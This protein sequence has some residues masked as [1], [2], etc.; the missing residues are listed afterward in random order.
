MSEYTDTI[1]LECNRKQSP[2]FLSKIEAGNPAH[3]TNNVG[4]GV[5]LDIGDQISVHSAYMS[6]IG[7]EAATI[8]IKGQDARDNLGRGQIFNMSDTIKIKKTNASF[9]G[10]ISYEY[11]P[12]DVPVQINDNEIHLTHSYYKTT[13]GEFYFTLP[14]RSAWVTGTPYYETY[15]IWNAYQTASNGFVSPNPY[16][17]INDYSENIKYRGPGNGTIPNASAYNVEQTVTTGINNDGSRYTLFVKAYNGNTEDNSSLVGHRDPALFNYNW[18]K[19]TY[20]YNIQEGFNSP[21]N[22]AQAFTD[23]FNNVTEIDTF[24]QVSTANTDKE[25][26][27]FDITAKSRTNEPFPCAFGYGY[28]E[29]VAQLYLSGGG[30]P[31]LIASASAVAIVSVVEKQYGADGTYPTGNW[32]ATTTADAAKVKIGMF[33]VESPTSET[34]SYANLVGS[35]I[36]DIR[37]HDTKA[38]GI[39]YIYFD[40]STTINNQHVKDLTYRFN[41]RDECRQYEHYYQACYATI[42]YKRPEI[43]ETGRQL[44]EKGFGVDPQLTIDGSFYVNAVTKFPLSVDNGNVLET[45]LDWNDENLLAVKRYL[46][47][48]E[49]YP[50]LFNTSNMSVASASLILNKST[51]SVDNSRYVHMNLSDIS[52]VEVHSTSIVVGNSVKFPV[53]SVT[54]LTAGDVLIEDNSGGKFPLDFTS[55][56]DRTAL[57]TYIEYIDVPGKI[58]ILSQAST[59]STGSGATF[60]LKFTRSKLGTDNYG[61]TNGSEESWAAPLFF[62]YNKDRKDIN[63]GIGKAPDRYRTLR[64]GWGVRVGVEGSYKIG[65][66]F[67]QYRLG[68]PQEWF[69]GGG[70]VSIPAGVRNIGFDK[71][72]NAYSTASLSLYNGL[73]GKYGTEFRGDLKNGT[74]YHTYQDRQDLEGIPNAK[75]SIPGTT[76]SSITLMSFDNNTEMNEVYIGANDPVLDFDADQSR[77]VFKRLHTPEIV[78]TDAAQL[79]ASQEVGDAEVICYKINKRLSRLNYSPNFTP[80]AHTLLGTGADQKVLLDKNIIPY[81]IM[82]ARSG[83]FLESYGCDEKNWAQSLWNLLGFSYEQFHRTLDNRLVRY[84]NIELTCTTPTTN[85]LIQ[86]TDLAQFDKS[87]DLTTGQPESIPYP[88]YIDNFSGNA[89]YI[90]SSTLLG[91]QDFPAIVQ[92]CSSTGI[93]ADNLPRKM[94]SPIYL[95]K[96]D[97]LSPAYIGG[98]E[99]T[100]KLPVIAVVPKNSGY[101]DF[102]NGGED[103]IF[104]NTIPRTIQNIKTA[105]SDA[106]GTDSRLDDGSCVIYKI[107]KTRQSNSQVFQ[108]IM[109]PPPKK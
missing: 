85:A 7:N 31:N 38:P 71:H 14:R 98:P 76:T 33:C 34:I 39:V 21:A 37:S 55:S 11:T 41:Y 12:R 90:V 47:T 101:G 22:V 26:R 83:I 62:D 23:Q 60:T 84:N 70:G 86:T 73:A 106:D 80:Y 79:S 30:N 109:N 66:F 88:Q 108:D 105:I 45:S 36:I 5:K 9:L 68:I 19:R 43:Q 15:E 53:S 50:E 81:S 94:I 24:Q 99:S 13:N 49:L 96:S 65:F 51:L 74:R 57:R 40:K 1:L 100:S 102:Y 28:S 52:A 2:E 27:N 97:L 77:F 87:V 103:T 54:G 32:I 4:D 6:A 44:D 72:F 92:S 104:T 58:L 61:L 16:V 20:T 63:D 78:G 48:Q 35:Q 75:A 67:G 95:V 3:W 93:V 29:Q 25:N 59:A 8:E 46:D 42:G 107:V 91:Y 69:G 64:Y 17:Y 82:D 10:D 18:Y 56:N 89:S